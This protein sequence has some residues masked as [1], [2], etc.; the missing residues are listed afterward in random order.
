LDS[1]ES[2]ERQNARIAVVTG[3]PVTAQ[4]VKGG[5]NATPAVKLGQNGLKIMSFW[6]HPTQRSPIQKPHPPSVSQIKE[7]LL[8][9]H[10]IVAEA[11]AQLTI[12]DEG[13]INGWAK[14]K[15]QWYRFTIYRF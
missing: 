4:K 6:T 9:Y 14:E 8:E 12:N 1:H 3:T 2:I 5:R 11:I 10:G 15:D 7:L 13:F